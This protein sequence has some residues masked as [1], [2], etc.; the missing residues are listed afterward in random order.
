M[1]ALPRPV[2]IRKATRSCGLMTLKQNTFSPTLLDVNNANLK[3]IIGLRRQ[4]FPLSPLVLVLG[5][6]PQLTEEPGIQICCHFVSFIP[7]FRTRR[8]EPVVTNAGAG[9]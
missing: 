1:P 9:H 8:V 4:R 2:A 7:R 5:D 6:N 3:S